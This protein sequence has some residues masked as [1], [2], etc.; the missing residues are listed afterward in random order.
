MGANLIDL[1]CKKTPYYDL[2]V[3]SLNSDPRSSTADVAGLGVI[4]ADVVKAKA[5]DSLN[6]INELLTQRP[7]DKLLANCVDYYHTV[8]EGD[9]PLAKDAFASGNPKLADQGMSDAGNVIDLCESQFS[10]GSSPLT[11]KNK[12]AHD[13]AAV[14]AGIARSMF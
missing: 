9:V 8:T 13:V 7:G 11:D 10:E 5:T 6:K 2:C 4:M 14:G 1:T 3:T 12:A